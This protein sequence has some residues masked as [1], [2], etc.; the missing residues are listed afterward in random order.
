[1]IYYKAKKMW[2]GKVSVRSFIVEYCRKMREPLQIEYDGRI[3]K[4][5]NLK[6]Y[7][8]DERPQIAQR[9]D[10]YIKKGE[11]YRLYD[12]EFFPQEEVNPA[13]DWEMEGLKKMLIAWK[14][15]KKPKQLSLDKTKE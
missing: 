5:K 15:S 7:T 10:K 2:Q 8:C 1:M 12:Y 14:N 13:S 4:V 3:M 6:D 11:I 9:S